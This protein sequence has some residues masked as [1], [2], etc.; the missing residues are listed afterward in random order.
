MIKVQLIGYVGARPVVRATQKG[1]PVA[2]FNVAVHGGK[3]ANGEEKSTWY[4]VTCWDG[5]AELADKIVQKGDLIWIEGTP[6]I[7]SWSDKNDVEHTEISI[8]AKYIQVLSRSRKQ[9]EP[10]VQASSSR[11]DMQQSLEELPF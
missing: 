8:T 1:R 7:S 3:D 2:N 6:E 9:G 5:R 4:P 10:E 11:A